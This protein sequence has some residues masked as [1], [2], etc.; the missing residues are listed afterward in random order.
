[1][2]GEKSRGGEM[3]ERD[4]EGVCCCGIIWLGVVGM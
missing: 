2:N 1:M 4:D 3:M